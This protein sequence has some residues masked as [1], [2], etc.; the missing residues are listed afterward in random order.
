M[1]GIKSFATVSTEIATGTAKKTILQIKA[2]AN[3]R[4]LVREFSISFKGVTNTD[5]PIK[6][7]LSTQS[8]NGTMDAITFVK[9]DVSTDEALQ[10]TGSEDA[11]AEPTETAVIKQFEVHPQGSYT[12][13]ATFGDEII[14]AGGAY[15][16]LV[17]TAGVTVNCVASFSV[18][19]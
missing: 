6:C 8:T 10:A 11:S 13:Q 16:G 18:E 2:P 17:V 5:A 14:V 15:L 19:E 1:A 3:Q 4:L 7:E 12:Y 9:A